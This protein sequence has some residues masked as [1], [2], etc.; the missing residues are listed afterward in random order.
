MLHIS[1][2]TGTLDLPVMYAQSPRAEGIQEF[3]INS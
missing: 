1:C 2:D 3:I